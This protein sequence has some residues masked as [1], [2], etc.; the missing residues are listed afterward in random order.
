MAGG[1]QTGGNAHYVVSENG[2]QLR[3]DR[4]VSGLLHIH[5]VHHPRRLS[6][7]ALEFSLSFPEVNVTNFG[8]NSTT[9]TYL[10]V[11]ASADGAN[12]MIFGLKDMQHKHNQ[13]LQVPILTMK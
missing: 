11:Y 6:D 9:G 10:K 13:Q 1:S 12:V 2:A 8:A 3:N 7:N 4:L 5:A